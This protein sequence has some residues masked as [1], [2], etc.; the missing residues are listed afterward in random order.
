MYLILQ[1]RTTSVPTV[2]AWYL[3]PGTGTS[4]YWYVLRTT[5]VLVLV[6]GT[7]RF[8]GLGM[9]PLARDSGCTFYFEDQF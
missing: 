8:A 6:L 9:D 4:R 5:V 1:F 2:S 7:Y 3:V